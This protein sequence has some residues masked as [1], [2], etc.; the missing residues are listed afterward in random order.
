[1][2]E[3]THL[4]ELV[5]YPALVISQ[6]SRQQEVLDLLADKSGAKVKDLMDAKGNWKCFFDY[7]YIPGTTQEVL[8]AVCIDTDVVAVRTSAQKTLELYISVLCSHALMSLDR[9]KFPGVRG[10]R[11]NNLLRYIDMAL[12]LDRDFG[13]GKLELKSVRTTTSGNSSFAKKTMT[14]LIPDFNLVR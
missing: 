7:E 14:Y 6:I 3:T 1:M 5:D 2:V 12:R 8:T 11:I 13:I 4:D 10:N 9:A